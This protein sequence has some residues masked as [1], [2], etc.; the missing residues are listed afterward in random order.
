M[1]RCL[2]TL[3]RSVHSLRAA[4]LLAIV[5]AFWVAQM[6]G[7]THG[8]SHLGRAHAVQHMAL[9]SDCL[10]AAA[11]GAAPTPGDAPPPPVAMP[12]VRLPAPAVTAPMAAERALYRSRAPP[13]TPT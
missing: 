9:C 11:A 2:P 7:L 8:L 10:A 5:M 1:I 13:P 4:W 12:D 6:H 3:P